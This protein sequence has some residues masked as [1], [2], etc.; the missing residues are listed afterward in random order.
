MKINILICTFL[1]FK[2]GH[3]QFI[4]PPNFSFEKDTIYGNLSDWKSNINHG[5]FKSLGIN[6]KIYYPTDGSFMYSIFSEKNISGV[7]VNGYLKNSFPINSR[8]LVISYESIF[9]SSLPEISKYRLQ[10]IFFKNNGLKSEVICSFD[11]LIDPINNVSNL[12]DWAYLNLDLSKSYISNLMPDSCTILFTCDIDPLIPNVSNILYVDDI[13]FKLTGL[14]EG[15]IAS[16]YNNSIVIFPN[17]TNENAIIRF[18]CHSIEEYEIFIYDVKGSLILTKK[19]VSVLDENNVNVSLF[20]YSKGIY[21]IVLKKG[22]LRYNRQLI[23][24]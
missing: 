12:N 14:S 15:P 6:H 19:G 24:E 10:L 23:V 7:I 5:L 2:L 21:N 16:Y 9:I 22:G 8:P 11:T 20:N 1:L 17:P 4:Y 3:S 18:V 13:K